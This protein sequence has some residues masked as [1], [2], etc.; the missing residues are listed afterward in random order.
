MCPVSSIMSRPEYFSYNQARRQQEVVP[1]DDL[2]YVR[3]TEHYRRPSAYIPDWRRDNALNI[4][5]YR[6]RRARWIKRRTI[7]LSKIRRNEYIGEGLLQ[8][9]IEALT[10]FVEAKNR[11]I[12]D[13]D[14]FPYNKRLLNK[15]S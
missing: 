5:I 4:R 2:S 7:L 3:S 15:Y 14:M 12:R 11:L 6:Q 8:D 13:S 9:T 1:F 10:S